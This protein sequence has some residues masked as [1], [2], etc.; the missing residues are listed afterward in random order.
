VDL[1]LGRKVV[2]L[3]PDGHQVADSAGTK[4]SYKKLLIATGGTPRELPFGQ[5]EILYYRSLDDYHQLRAKVEDQARFGVIGGGFI[6]SELAAALA[7]NERDVSL[8]FPEEGIGQKIFPKDLSRYLNEYFLENGVQVL[9]N[10]KV[11]GLDLEEGDRALITERP[12]KGPREKIVVDA[13]IAGIGINPNTALAAEAGIEV[14]DGVIVNQHLQTSHPDIYAAGDVA[15]YEI[16]VL[17]QPGR[18]EHEDN[19]NA[20]GRVA[21]LNMVGI[22]TPYDYLPMFYSDLFDL[23]YE[24][25]GMLDSRMKTVAD[26]KD[27]FQKGIV[28]YFDEGRVRGVLLWNVWGKLDSARELI[29]RP[30]PLPPDRIGGHIGMS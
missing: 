2:K 10:R 19:A 23:G 30:D 16:P 1:T 5:G 6:G 15:R 27:P 8:I 3:D 12:E 7:M 20:M 24:A 14:D 26:W 21:G 22:P 25:V 13:V 29:S 28:Y 17:G 9:P 18:F 11:V 4:Y